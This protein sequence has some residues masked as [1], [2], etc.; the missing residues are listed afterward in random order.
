MAL[1]KES[2][3]TIPLLMKSFMT[4]EAVPTIPHLIQEVLDLKKFIAHWI[5]D[6][7]ES[8]MGHTKVHHFKFYVDS[9][10]TPILKYKI[11]CLR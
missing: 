1:H 2:F 6:G 11:Y 7:K 9:T 10:G 8:L 4:N 3:P 5:L